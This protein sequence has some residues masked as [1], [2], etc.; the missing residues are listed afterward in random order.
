MADAMKK[1]DEMGKAGSKPVGYYRRPAD[2]PIALVPPVPPSNAPFFNVP[3]K[4]KTKRFC[5]VVGSSTTSDGG[6]SFEVKR[7]R[8]GVPST[9]KS[10]TQGN[11]AANMT[12][13]IGTDEI[14][15]EDDDVF[16][17]T[18]SGLDPSKLLPEFLC[19]VVVE[20]GA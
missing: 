20:L 15:V 6:V 16:T 19:F 7:V 14:E 10:W 8:N 5:V 4:G 2:F 1:G 12:I 13:E 18:I 11:W 3:G 9:M 17:M